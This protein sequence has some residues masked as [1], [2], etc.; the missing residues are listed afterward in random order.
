MK[1]LVMHRY[2]QLSYEEVPEPKIASERDLIVKVK[3]AAICGS[4][5]HGFDGSTGRRKPPV[6]MGHEASGEIVAIGNGVSGFA[7]GDRVTFDSTIYC[8]SCYYCRRGLVNLCDNRRV[9]G[10]S[11]EEYR[12]DGCF[13]EYVRIPN[14]IAYR[15]PEGL[16]FV[17]ASL[18]E[19]A[20]VAAHAMSITPIEL[21]DTM[22]VVGTGLIGLLLIQ[23][24]KAAASGRV[25]AIDTDEKRLATARSLGAD[26]AINPASGTAADEIREI[27]QGRGADRVFEAVGASAPI[28]TALEVVRKGGSVTL[29]G[30]VSPK[31]ELPLQSVVTRQIMLFGSCAISGEYPAVLDM[32][33]R[34]KIDLDP[35]ISAVAPL[36][37]GQSWFDRLY[38]R[39][40]GLLKVVLEP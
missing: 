18:T 25:I 33:L 22:A 37:E 5:V 10:V 35:L 32:M 6:I 21:N 24:L 16:S 4:D 9:L 17:D 39:E 11:C 28:Q 14:H 7:V 12:Q 1:A 26:M 8:S 34:N 20:A 19:P 40:P 38:D 3:A 29:I 13:A 36:S 23:F 27:T 30:N 15:L 31:I 2:K